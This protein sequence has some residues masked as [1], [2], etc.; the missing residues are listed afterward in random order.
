MSMFTSPKV[1]TRHYSILNLCVGGWRFPCEFAHFNSSAKR[2]T[3]TIALFVYD[4]FYDTFL[5]RNKSFFLPFLLVGPEIH[6]STHSFLFYDILNFVNNIFFLN[7]CFQV[8][9]SVRGTGFRGVINVILRKQIGMS[10]SLM[11]KRHLFFKF[12]FVLMTLIASIIN[13]SVKKKNWKKNV[14]LDMVPSPSTQNPRP[15]T[16]RQTRYTVRP[17]LTESASMTTC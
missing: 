7:Q 1:A 10:W 15:S 6:N 3:P 12:L 14:T 16:K 2:Q 17:S 4:P 9:C 13:F 5:K 11:F 8:T